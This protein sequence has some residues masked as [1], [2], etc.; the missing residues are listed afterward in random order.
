MGKTLARQFSFY[1]RKIMGELFKRNAVVTFG[2]LGKDGVSVDGLRVL[3]K[4]KK[5]SEKTPNPGQIKIYNLNSTSRAILESGKAAIDT[6]TGKKE[7]I[8]KIAIILNVG[9]GPSVDQLFIGNVTKAK[10]EKQGPDLITTIEAGDGEKA[11]TEA[12]LD[13]SYSAGTS[14]KT[15]FK[16]ILK[17]M[18]DAGGIA[19][20]ALDSI[21]NEVTQNGITLSGISNVLLSKL[22]D[23]QGLEW[24]IQDHELQILKILSSSNTKAI[25]L[26]PETGLIGRP[27]KTDKGIEFK[28][29]LNTKIKPG[30]L[31][32]IESNSLD[33]TILISEAVFDGDTH[34]EVFSISGVGGEI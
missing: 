29:L 25:L 4:I 17:S 10:T 27:V 33:A 6:K 20:G 5:T 18:K 30:G 8:H 28:A 19:L 2:Q 26:T 14:Y 16:D 7:S 21:K 13:K 9:Y 15:M 1:M 11:F 23:R 22:T 12:R 32:R 3:F 31:V 34:G 24:S